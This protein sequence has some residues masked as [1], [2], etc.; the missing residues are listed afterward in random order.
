MTPPL[1]PLSLSLM[2][3]LKT[4]LTIT[5]STH[6]EAG[7][8]YHD[9]HHNEI[10]EGVKRAVEESSISCSWL[11]KIYTEWDESYPVEITVDIDKKK[12]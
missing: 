11:K 5:I 1:F 10:V 2:A 9:P 4:V 6:T 8:A 12:T 7:E 3:T